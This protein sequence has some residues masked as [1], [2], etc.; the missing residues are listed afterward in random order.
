MNRLLRPTGPPRQRRGS[1]ENVSVLAYEFKVQG[2]L[3]AV[4]D[5]DATGLHEPVEVYPVVAA[6]DLRR[7][8]KTGALFAV[9]IVAAAFDL[10]I[11]DDRQRDVAHRQMAGELP[12][13]VVHLLDRA[14][15]E[16][17]LREALRVEE[18]VGAQV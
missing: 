15:D 13:L 10:D 4:T 2:D 18:V 8:D 1:S 17:E 7:R 9:R 11:E 12:V 3:D 14:A 16:R 6:V 5:D